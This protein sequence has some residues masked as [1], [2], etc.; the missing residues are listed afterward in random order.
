MYSMHHALLYYAV[1]MMM[2][3]SGHTACRMHYRAHFS[4]PGKVPAT[5]CISGARLSPRFL[6]AASFA[7]L[8]I[9]CKMEWLQEKWVA[10]SW[11]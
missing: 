5:R 1:C 6:H 4:P 11:G 8:L 10:R 2:Q 7:S 3:Y 9:D